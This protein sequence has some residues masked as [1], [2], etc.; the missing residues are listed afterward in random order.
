MSKQWNWCLTKNLSDS[1]ACV[2]SAGLNPDYM[3][4]QSQAFLVKKTEGF[5]REWSL[6]GPLASDRNVLMLKLS[7]QCL[8]GLLSLPLSGP[9]SGLTFGFLPLGEGE[10]SLKFCLWMP[11][12]RQGAHE[13]PRNSLLGVGLREQRKGL[14]PFS[15]SK[16][17]L[18]WSCSIYR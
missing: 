11:Y 18:V 14:Q 17:Y 3:S 15:K 5:R 9:F 12:G 6:W 1:K 7:K 16:D 13:A 4:I 8:V 2:R 10:Q